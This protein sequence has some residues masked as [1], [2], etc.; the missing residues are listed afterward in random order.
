MHA[1]AIYRFTVLNPGLG[2]V[3]HFVLF[4]FG[5]AV[6]DFGQITRRVS[7][8]V[9]R[10][11]VEVCGK[12]RAV[13][14]VYL[15]RYLVDS[16]LVAE[17]YSITIRVRGIRIFCVLQTVDAVVYRHGEHVHGN[18][19]DARA[20]ADYHAFQLPLG[21]GLDGQGILRCQCTFLNQG[22]GGAVKG[23]HL[24]ADADTGHGAESAFAGGIIHFYGV[25]GVDIDI[26]RFQR[27][28]VNGGGG[29]V[30][31]LVHADAA[32]DAR[33]EHG[34][35]HA[36]RNQGGLH[37]G[38]VVR[39]N[40]NVSCVRIRATAGSFPGIRAAV[41]TVLLD[42]TVF[43]GS[44]GGGIFVDYAHA[45]VQG[46]GSG[47]AG[48]HAGGNV[49]IIDAILVG[50]RYLGVLGKIHHSVGNG[51]RRGAFQLVGVNVVAGLS[52]AFRPGCHGHGH[53]Q[54][55]HGLHRVGG[56]AEILGVNL[57][58]LFAGLGDLII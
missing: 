45:H 48:C 3:F 54:G 47:G 21:L 55:R 50:G 26:V 41:G 25:G 30:V 40:G 11:L 5:H 56:H 32:A 13:I 42:I 19:G 9:F 52:T 58:L 35:G 16:V 6:Q 31:D 22:A 36:G 20:H 46:T 43:H 53:V 27:A 2:L 23:V 37:L 34:G 12:V 24:H 7:G 39:L 57:V 8:T 10:T 51:G 38:S 4:V 29:P 49:H 18:A 33:A 1:G 17:V 44:G 28:T 15:V 14:G